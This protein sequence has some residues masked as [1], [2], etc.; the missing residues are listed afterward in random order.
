MWVSGDSADLWIQD[1]NVRVDTGATCEEDPPPYAKKVLVM[2]DSIDGDKN[3]LRYV[4][5]NRVTTREGLK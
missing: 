1:Y 4:R 5:R 2:L 3:V